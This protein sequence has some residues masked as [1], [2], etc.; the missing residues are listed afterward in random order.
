MKLTVG[1][2]SH[3]YSETEAGIVI[4]Q[5]VGEGVVVNEGTEVDLVI[6]DGPKVVTYTGSVSGSITAS[7]EE[8]LANGKNVVVTAYI[9]DGS[10][11]HEVVS[12]EVATVDKASIS[13]SG[14]VTGLAAAD[15]NISISVIDSDGVDVTAY[16]RN[17]LTLTFTQE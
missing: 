7:D 2:I 6:S 5:S 13:L 15:G 10:G 16:Y 9:N 4:R 8:F 12:V 3:E 17:S 11:S 14:S 1:K